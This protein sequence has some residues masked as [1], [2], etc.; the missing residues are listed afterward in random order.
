MAGNL[1]SPVLPDGSLLSVYRTLLSLI[2]PDVSFE[3]Y[4]CFVYMYRGRKLCQSLGIM[5]NSE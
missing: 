4:F 2:S 1:T 3:L 5:F